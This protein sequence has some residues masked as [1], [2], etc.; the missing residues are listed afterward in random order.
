MLSYL[1]PA[2]FSALRWA[3]YRAAFFLRYRR[4]MP[5]FVGGMPCERCS[6]RVIPLPSRA[7]RRR[8][9]P[10]RTMPR[11][12]VVLSTREA[13]LRKAFLGDPDP[14][15]ANLV[16]QRPVT[17]G[18]CADGPRPCPWVSCRHHL[19]LDV[20]EGGALRLNFPH[21]EPW[22]LEQTCSLDVAEAE[23]RTL[24]GAGAMLNLTRERTRQLEAKALIFARPGL[25]KLETR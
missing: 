25:A 3:A 21:L 9:T 17:R 13:G 5:V 22:E 14:R 24:D 20:L 12:E 23:E 2:W 18:D 16:A 1:S 6:D 10:R 19:Y 4:E 7:W 8:Y 11:P 15:P